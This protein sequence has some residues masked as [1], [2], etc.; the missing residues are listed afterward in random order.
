LKGCSCKKESH[1]A[2]KK[3]REHTVNY[4]GC[5]TDCLVFLK[6][7]SSPRIRRLGRTVG[8]N[9]GVRDPCAEAGGGLGASRG[10]SLPQPPGTL[11]GAEGLQ[12][13]HPG[14]G[15]GAAPGLLPADAWP[16][17]TGRDAA[18]AGV[19]Q[20]EVGIWSSPLAPAG[21][22]SLPH[23]RLHLASWVS[24]AGPALTLCTET[25]VG[26]TGQPSDSEPNLGQP[27][28]T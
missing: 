10:G 3:N 5:C 19:Q 25:C 16:R 24:E 26:R 20:E 8:F 1:Q 11:A 15:I 4:P 21:A 14:W 9:S 6:H 2:K 23:R 27:A 17:L 13:R 28:A 18:G 22:G 12:R 7:F